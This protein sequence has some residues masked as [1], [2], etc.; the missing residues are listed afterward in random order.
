MSWGKSFKGEHIPF[1]GVLYRQILSRSQV[2]SA[3]RHHG[4]LGP[5]QQ[6]P[7]TRH[8]HHH[9]HHGPHGNHSHGNHTHHHATTTAYCPIEAQK[10]LLGNHPSGI[11]DIIPSACL[12]E[13]REGDCCGTE[14]PAHCYD[15]HFVASRM[16][17]FYPVI[18]YFHRK[19]GTQN[20]VRLGGNEGEGETPGH[21]G[22]ETQATLSLFE[23][24]EGNGL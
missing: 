1:P 8:K 21:L 3:M 14:A 18:E 11:A 23:G 12:R 15:P 6:T 7:H 17:G 5:R 13:E 19:R 10:G 9:H 20:F 2:M 24:G 22:I 16:K 4:D